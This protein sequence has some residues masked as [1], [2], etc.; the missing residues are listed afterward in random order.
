MT[1]VAVLNQQRA[2]PTL[3]KIDRLRLLDFRPAVSRCSQEG[4]QDPQGEAHVGDPVPQ[5]LMHTDSSRDF[6]DR[7]GERRFPTQ[8]SVYCSAESA[9]TTLSAPER[10]DILPF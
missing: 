2:N 6:G 3:E 9:P 10:R 8:P 4:A 5:A 7:I 1:F